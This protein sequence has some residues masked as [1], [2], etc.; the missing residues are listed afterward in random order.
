MP[1]A[2]GTQTGT[3]RFLGAFDMALLMLVV[4]AESLSSSPG[5]SCRQAPSHG[6]KAIMPAIP[7]PPR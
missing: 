6:N 5:Q 4:L 2:S 1:Y 7:G 3:W